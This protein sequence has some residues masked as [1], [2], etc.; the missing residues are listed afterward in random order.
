MADLNVRVWQVSFRGAVADE[1]IDQQDPTPR[2]RFFAEHLPSTPPSFT[3]VAIED[4]VIVGFV[5]VGPNRDPDAADL[6]EVYGLYVDP[7]QHRR[8]IGTVLMRRALEWIG[9][10]GTGATLW[11]LRAVAATRRFYEAMG[12]HPDGTTKTETAGDHPLHQVRYRIN[13]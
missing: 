9:T 2:A 7:D 3:E 4:D 5:H 13:G 6:L 10:T 1:V 12:W 11:T 8:G